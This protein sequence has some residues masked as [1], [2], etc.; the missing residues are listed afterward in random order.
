MS[1]RTACNHCNTPMKSRVKHQEI[2]GAPEDLRKTANMLPIPK[3]TKDTG[4]QLPKGS[5]DTKEM[6]YTSCYYSD[7]NH[8]EPQ[9]PRDDTGVNNKY[10]ANKILYETL[11]DCSLSQ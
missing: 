9:V 11:H 2:A 7:Q 1:L 10:F 8:L 3:Q 6:S 4:T 5:D